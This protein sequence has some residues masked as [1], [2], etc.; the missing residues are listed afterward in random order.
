MSSKKGILI[1]AG[2]ISI[3][4]CLLLWFIAIVETPVVLHK[5]M[6]YNG[7]ETIGFDF[8]NR[9]P[10]VPSGDTG[11]GRHLFIHRYPIPGNGYVNG[12]E[13][14]NDYK[15][16]YPEKQERIVLL[17]LRPDIGSWKIFY[18]YDTVDDNPV[19]TD[20]ITRIIFKSPVRVRKGDIFATYQPSDSPTGGIPLNEDAACIDGK[21]S[22]LFGFADESLQINAK[23]SDQGFSG[24]RDYFIHLLFVPK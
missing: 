19:R 4:G 5:V 2:I 15:N 22:G 17:L 16:G 13:Y 12:F 18:R 14:L 1:F 9:V 8:Q 24:C 23:I 6:N 10:S 20:G 21:S 11:A 7:T 3:F